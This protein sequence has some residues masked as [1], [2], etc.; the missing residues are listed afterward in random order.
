MG[1][2]HD[3]GNG[4]V[5]V[6]VWVWVLGVVWDMWTCG[7]VATACGCAVMVLGV[8]VGRCGRWVWC[9]GCG[10]MVANGRSEPSH[11]V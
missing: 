9:W 1:V 8:G 4:C 11:G 7:H 5:W 6:C 10:Q 2:G 3:F